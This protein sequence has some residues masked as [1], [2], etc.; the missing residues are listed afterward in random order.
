MK[1]VG[2][3]WR[4]AAL[5]AVL[6]LAGAREAAAQ[7]NLVGYYNPIFDEDFVERIPGPDIGDY[8]GLPIEDPVYLAEPL[9]KSN[10]FQLIPNGTMEPYPCRP[11]VEVPRT[12]GEVPHH[13]INEAAH[14]KEFPAK[15]DLPLE[16]AQG[17]SETAL[18]EYQQKLPTMPRRTPPSPS[19]EKRAR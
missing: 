4:I 1:A 9:V 2:V 14:L 19:R 8:A 7:I 11:A 6:T 13:G 17:G 16:A 15:H 12:A 18:P 3:R 5:M 10:G